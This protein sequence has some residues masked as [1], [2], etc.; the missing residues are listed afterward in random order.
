MQRGQ[1]RTEG[2][3]HPSNDKRTAKSFNSRRRNTGG[4]RAFN[5]IISPS[6]ASRLP[7]HEATPIQFPTAESFG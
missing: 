4:S 6:H 2:Y 7:D 3:Q 1:Y 5:L